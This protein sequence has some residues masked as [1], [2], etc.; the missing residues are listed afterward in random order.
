MNTNNLQTIA[1]NV[2]LKPADGTVNV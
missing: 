2:K 1:Q